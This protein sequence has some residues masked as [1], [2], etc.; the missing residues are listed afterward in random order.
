MSHA[1][2]TSP[3]V[4][5]DYRQPRLS[6]ADDPFHGGSP[7]K[8]S[9]LR[10]IDQSVDLLGLVSACRFFVAAASRTV[11]LL[12]DRTLEGGVSAGQ[13]PTGRSCWLMRE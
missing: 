13:W 10:A 9:C 4:L 6:R 8:S 11:A 7:W 3:G 5:E 1:T 12:R 2:L